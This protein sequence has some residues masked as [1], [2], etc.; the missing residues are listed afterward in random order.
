M[1]KYYCILLAAVFIT[2]CQLPALGQQAGAFARLGFGSR[3]MAMGNGLAADISGAA[4][5]Y[6]NP[7]LAPYTSSANIR[8]SYALL[9]HDRALQY[10]GFGTPLDERAGLAIGFVHAG[11]SGI[12]GRDQSGYHTQTYAT[13]EYALFTAFGIRL[14]ERLSAGLGLRLYRASLISSVEPASG[15][16]LS[17]GLTARI[18]DRLHLGLVA[19]DVLARYSWDTSPLHGAEGRQTTDRFPV[20]IRL[21]AAYRPMEETVQLVVEYESRVLYVDRT[22]R[23]VE[24]V[25]HRPVQTIST[26]V[27]RRYWGGLRLGGEWQVVDPFVVRGGV[28]RVRPWANAGL[29]PSAGFSIEQ[30][31]DGV[32]GYIDYAAVAEPFLMEIRHVLG[33]RVEF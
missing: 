32:T 13:N 6:Y 28:S 25:G 10:L 5:P 21:G 4:T 17:A 24:V 18:T 11:V 27:L 16:G 19:D 22:T 31:I 12:D 9:S 3:G 15:L 30:A 2:V 1:R 26:D 29:S 7:A 20:R 33:L 14:S 8:T 23:G